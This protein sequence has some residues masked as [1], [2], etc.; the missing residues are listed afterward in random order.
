MARFLKKEV[1][2]L[3]CL[4]IVW[5]MVPGCSVINEFLGATEFAIC[6]ELNQSHFEDIR[7]AVRRNGN[8][9]YII[10]ETDHSIYRDRD[11][12]DSEKISLTEAEQDSLN[13]IL[14]H[15][16][17]Y[18]GHTLIWRI[19][20]TDNHVYFLDG[21][22][23]CGIIYT[24][25]IDKSIEQINHGTDHLSYSWLSPGWYKIVD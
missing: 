3:V 4:G 2:F 18:E 10:N 25:N 24:E 16:N 5:L 19:S 22:T 14:L 8:G 15:R 17:C 12:T 1:F 9:V 7:A 13:T 23:G 21:D 20:V 11:D 6:D